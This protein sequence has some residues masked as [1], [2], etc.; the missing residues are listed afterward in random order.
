VLKTTAV[1]V[2]GAGANKRFKSETCKLRYPVKGVPLLSLVLQEISQF[3]CAELIFVQGAYDLTDLIPED[4]TIINNDQWELG[5]S[6][7][8]NC[9]L[10]YCQKQ[11]FDQAVFVFGNEVPINKELLEAVSLT[12]SP[13]AYP[14]YKNMSFRPVKIQSSLWPTIPIDSDN[15]VKIFHGFDSNVVT[16]IEILKPH[17]IIK[18]LS[19]LKKLETHL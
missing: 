16:T 8:V 1:V 19:D 14:T 5:L 6:S 10:D 18:T 15:E 13:V 9:A 2:L 11:G 4:F 3:N 17:V 7:S 12:S